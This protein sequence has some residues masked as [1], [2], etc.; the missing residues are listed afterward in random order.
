LLDSREV[1]MLFYPLDLGADEIVF[2]WS[3][4]T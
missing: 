4:D 1:Q 3:E 2:S